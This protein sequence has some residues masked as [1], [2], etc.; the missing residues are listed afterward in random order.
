M[1]KLF[2]IIFES[3]IN[4][5]T[6]AY[7]TSYSV[8]V[9]WIGF[10]TN[11]DITR[12]TR[13]TLAFPPVF[14]INLVTMR[15]CHSWNLWVDLS[16]YCSPI[17]KLRAMASFSIFINDPIRSMNHF[18]KKGV[19]QSL[20]SIFDG[21]LKDWKLWRQFHDLKTSLK[22]GERVRSWIFVSSWLWHPRI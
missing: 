9:Q 1:W 14:I 17:F 5:S 16:C 22:Y 11:F 12:A 18:V 6:F 15:C 8:D 3:D 19:S 20:A 7:G 13:N 10:S 21:F 2:F 4:K